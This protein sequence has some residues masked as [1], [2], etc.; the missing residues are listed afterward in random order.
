MKRLTIILCL[1]ILIGC[2][3]EKNIIDTAEFE[4]IQVEILS[5][6]R[7]YGDEIKIRRESHEFVIDV[8]GMNP[9]KIDFC[10]VDG[11]EVE[12]AIGVYKESPHHK[13]TVRR[14]FLY[15]IDFENERLKPKLRISRLHNPLVDFAMVDIDEDSLD[16]IISI[17]ET[18]QGHYIIG[19]YNWTNFAFEREYFSEEIKIKPTYLNKEGRVEINGSEYKLFLDKEEIKWR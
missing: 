16:E 17:E 5:R 15:N 8:N 7:E 2:K 12:L 11:G 14:L 13:E 18:I 6:D 10:N 9:W 3:T 1:I 4:G 19:G